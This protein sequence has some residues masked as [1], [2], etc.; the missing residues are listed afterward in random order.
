MS[1]PG[2]IDIHS[3]MTPRALPVDPGSCA[4]WPCM[5]CQGEARATLMLGDKP[6][7][8]LDDRSWDVARRCEDMDRD[9]VA[10][11]L[12][13]P[14]PELLSYWQ[15]AAHAEYLADHV[16]AA[17]AEMVAR[18]P[19]R[20]RGLAMVPM[21][22]PERAA[23]YMRDL[24][25]RFG[26]DGIEIGSNVNGALPGEQRF[27]PVFAAAEAGDLAVF[28]HALHPVATAAVM[29]H[30]PFFTPMVGFPLDVAMAGASLITEGVLE[31]HPRLRIALSHGGGAM[32][33]LIGRLDQ[34]WHMVPELRDRLSTAPSA[35]ARRL[36][37]DSNVYE[38]ALLR[39]VAQDM[40][41]GRVCAGTDYPYLIM[42]EDPA[43]FIASAGLS[44]AEADSVRRGAAT[45]FLDIG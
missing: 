16:N 18:R 7:R 42:Q 24:K 5:R 38:P 22:E 10:I 14:M 32:A 44:V 6:F 35:Q 11:Q 9:G 31:R 37:Y 45:T 36:F 2:L 19:D 27:A 3:H 39:H 12:L 15:D 28:V 17:I 43:A 21:Q 40:A 34:G 4:P 41:P 20:F 29:R 30:A 1:T 23:R 26:V 33:S 25:A 13:S 8:E